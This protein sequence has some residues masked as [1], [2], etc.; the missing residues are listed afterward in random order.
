MSPVIYAA[1]I[2][3]VVWLWLAC[4]GL[5]FWWW[6]LSKRDEDWYEGRDPYE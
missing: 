2:V 3:L 1:A 5:A 6:L 4:V